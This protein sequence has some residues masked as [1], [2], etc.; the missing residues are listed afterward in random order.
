MIF[1]WVNLVV[2]N[3][4]MWSVSDHMDLWR[5]SDNIIQSILLLLVYS[6]PSTSDDYI[7]SMIL[8]IPGDV[9]G[10]GDGISK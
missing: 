1:K 3:K 5:N 9:I 4:S 10:K 2:E 6:I 7:L 8:L